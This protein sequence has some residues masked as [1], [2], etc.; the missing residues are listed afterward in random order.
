MEDIKLKL[1]LS[2]F[3]YKTLDGQTLKPIKEAGYQ[4]IANLLYNNLSD[5]GLIAP[6]QSM[7][8]T[9]I[10]EI[11]LAQKEQ[12]LHVLPAVFNLPYQVALTEYLNNAKP[13]AAKK[14][15]KK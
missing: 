7:L 1:D 5:L 10:C 14:A 11:T 15:E 8:A 2:N 6:L 4:S 3:E 13:V 9:G 12:I